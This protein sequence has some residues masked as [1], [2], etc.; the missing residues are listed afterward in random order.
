MDLDVTAASFTLAAPAGSVSTT[1][2][3]AVSG[4]AGAVSLTAP[5]GSVFAG[6]SA[7]VTGTPGALECAAPA[8]HVSISALVV[9]SPATVL[10]AGVPGSVVTTATVSVPGVPGRIVLRAPAGLVGVVFHAVW[11]DLPHKQ[12][13]AQVTSPVTFASTSGAPGNGIMIKDERG[14]VGEVSLWLR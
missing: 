12:G 2:S 14:L 3:V 5:T 10:L 7:S 4:Q 1:Y 13:S 9:G 8:G 11:R 6:N